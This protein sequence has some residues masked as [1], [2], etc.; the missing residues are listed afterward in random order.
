MPVTYKEVRTRY[1][2]VERNA[3]LLKF[4]AASTQTNA[5]SRAN[6][7]ELVCQ[8]AVFPPF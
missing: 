4:L 8:R 2:D 1:T 5:H 6:Y 7:W 3:L